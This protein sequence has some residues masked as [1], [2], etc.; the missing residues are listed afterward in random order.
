MSGLECVFGV[1]DGGRRLGEVR[2]VVPGLHNALNATAAIAVGTALGQPFGELA[3]G[4]GAFTGARRRFELKGVAAGVRVYDD[5]AHH[6]TEL[7]ALLTAARSAA[8][9]GRVVVAFQPHRY[10][11]TAAF[12]EALGAALGLADEV[13]V[14]EVY[15]AGEDPIPGATGGLV[16]GSVPLPPERVVFEPSWL[17]V[18]DVVAGRARSGDLVLTVG[19]GDVTMLGPEILARL[20]DGGEG[21]AV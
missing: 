7:L 10:T 16:A 2:L 8:A 17:A 18:P 4:L 12:G 15:A 21:S 9:G 6:P 1:I 5:Y 11:R 14:M 19:A 3:A 20:E 13:V